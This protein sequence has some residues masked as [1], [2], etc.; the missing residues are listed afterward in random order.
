[1]APIEQFSRNLYFGGPGEWIVVVSHLALIG[2]AVLLAWLGFQRRPNPRASLPARAAL[3]LAVFALPLAVFFKADPFR[4]R[5]RIDAVWVEETEAHRRVTVELFHRPPKGYEIRRAEVFALEPT[6]HP[7]PKQD[8]LSSPEVC[9]VRGSDRGSTRRLVAQWIRTSTV[10]V[11]CRFD[12]EGPAHLG[13]EPSDGVGGGLRLS[14]V[15][16]ESGSR[17]FSVDLTPAVGGVPSEKVELLD[18][19]WLGDKL[20]LWLV[21]DRRA[22]SEVCVKPRDGELLS[23]RV[24]L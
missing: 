23:A 20:C 19:R 11:P 2:F 10:P 12:L 5:G 4:I 22:L 3:A 18:P 13:I 14:G 16:A 9:A 21:R 17:L 6:G 24:I 7:H 1:M 15:A 8:V